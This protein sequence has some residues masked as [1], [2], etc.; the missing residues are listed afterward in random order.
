M[1]ISSCLCCILAGLVCIIGAIQN[2]IL[3]LCLRHHPLQTER[4]H[5]SSLSRL[6]GFIKQ[7]FLLPATFVT[8][9]LCRRFY[10]SIPLQSQTNL[11][12]TYLAV[13]LIFMCVGYHIFNENLYWPEQ[14]AIQ[15]TRYVADRS[16]ILGFAQIPLLI[17]FS[18]R[19][20][21]L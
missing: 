20:N 1:L 7:Q 4:D 19:N 12:S 18:G 17:A 10:F 15:L 16:G 8:G 9:H 14:P 13:N 2:H 3:P 11:I 5:K 6:A 21:V